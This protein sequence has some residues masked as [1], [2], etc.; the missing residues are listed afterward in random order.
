MNCFAAVRGLKDPQSAFA[1]DR[2]LR[3]EVRQAGP[4]PWIRSD[5]PL[6][7]TCH[8]RPFARGASPGAAT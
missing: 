4:D 1:V 8:W 2:V 7:A 3:L 6:G 5:A